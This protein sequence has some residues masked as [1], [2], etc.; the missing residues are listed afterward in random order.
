MTTPYSRLP[1]AAMGCYW[2]MAM[3][4]VAK[5]MDINA[6]NAGD[7]DSQIAYK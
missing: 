4:R 3:K 1:C 7:A 2:G 5:D 6:N